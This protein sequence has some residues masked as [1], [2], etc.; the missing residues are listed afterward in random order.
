LAVAFSPDG[1]AVLTGSGE[2]NSPDKPWG[3]AWGEARLWRV[4]LDTNLDITL[5]KLWIEVQTGRELDE[6]G[7]LRYLDSATW[8]K[9]YK[10]LLQRAGDGQGGRIPNWRQITRAKGSGISR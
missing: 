6:H 9:R 2:W 8:Q 1:K 3:K 10:E 7:S 4:S 5:T